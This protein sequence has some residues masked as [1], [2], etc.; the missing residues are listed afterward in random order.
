MSSS[1]SNERPRSLESIRRLPGRVASVFSRAF[2]AS[3]GT[4]VVL[5]RIDH[6]SWRGVASSYLQFRA[7]LDTHFTLKAA[8]IEIDF[9]QVPHIDDGVEI[10][11]IHPLYACGPVSSVA[12][13]AQTGV[14]VNTGVSAG[15]PVEIG[16][17]G[18]RSSTTSTT[19]N[20][21]CMLSLHI[22]PGTSTQSKLAVALFE[23][24][25]LRDGLPHRA[26]F[27]FGLVLAHSDVPYVM[28]CAVLLKPKGW[29][30]IPFLG[31][32]RHNSRR[33]KVNP[34]RELLAMHEPS[35][36]GL[37]F[38]LDSTRRQIQ[39]CIPIPDD[40]TVVSDRITDS[41]TADVRGEWH[42]L[43]VP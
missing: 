24:R 4:H 33:T 40:F 2:T 10:L 39:Q 20:S 5:H 27:D 21:A 31:S 22:L 32:I 29:R 37:D 13:S 41:F 36:Q 7:T 17:T 12:F 16:A 43:E 25:Q 34:A 26:T 28:D 1:S 19:R 35:L 30:K 15:L 18:T 6:G 3:T 9:D 23:D 11:W 14:D 38:S 42:K 8:F